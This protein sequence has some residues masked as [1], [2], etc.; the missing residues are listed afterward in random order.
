M[1]TLKPVVRGSGA[2]QAEV[3]KLGP[4]SFLGDLDPESGVISGV[5]ISGKILAVPYVRGSTVGPYVLW[6]AAARGNAPVAIVARSVDLMLITASA[7]AGVPLFQG[8][9]PEGCIEID[10]S[11]GDYERCR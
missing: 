8:E 6:H 10:L 5:R 2:V 4:I 11:T 3:V 7:L 1:P 9:L